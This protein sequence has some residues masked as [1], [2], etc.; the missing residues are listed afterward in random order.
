MQTIP[1]AQ[2]SYRT[3]FL[4]AYSYGVQLVLMWLFS[5]ISGSAVPKSGK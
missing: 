1:R 3:I 5:S 4:F 2:R